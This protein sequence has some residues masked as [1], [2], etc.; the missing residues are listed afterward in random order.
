MGGLLLKE[1]L[2]GAPETSAACAAA[3]LPTAFGAKMD[4]DEGVA[5]VWKTVGQCL[6]VQDH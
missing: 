1:L 4:E 6:E 2:K 5:A 3:I